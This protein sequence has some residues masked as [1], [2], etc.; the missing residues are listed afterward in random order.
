MRILYGMVV[1]EAWLMWGLLA[2]CLV[3]GSFTVGPRLLVQQREIRAVQTD[4][5]VSI[6][7]EVKSPGVYTLP[8]GARVADVI[9]LAGGLTLRAD[10]ALVQSAALIANGEALYIPSRVTSSGQVRISLNHATLQ[11]LQ[12]LPGVGAVMAQRI[13]EGRPYSSV[14]A[15]INVR[16]IGEKTLARLRALVT[17]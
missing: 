12:S 11:E 5:T 2:A 10:T 8:W 16:G 17:L 1:R 15:L 7:G 14:D 9:E 4:I 13:I 6:A 3:V